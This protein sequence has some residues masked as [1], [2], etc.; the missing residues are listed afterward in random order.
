MTVQRGW[1]LV[2]CDVGQDFVFLGFLATSRLTAAFES[3]I[4]C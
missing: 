2:Y 4:H 1:L 3:S